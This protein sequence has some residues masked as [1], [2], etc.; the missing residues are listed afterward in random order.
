VFVY[1]KVFLRNSYNPNKANEV[2]K[3]YLIPER[4]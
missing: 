3:R 2:K 1:S 4:N